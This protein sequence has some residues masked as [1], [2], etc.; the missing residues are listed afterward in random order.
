MDLDQRIDLVMESLMQKYD[1]RV[2]EGGDPYRVLIRTILSQRTR[3]ENTDRASAQLFSQYHTMTE[4][5]GADPARL[6]PLIRPAGFYRVKAQRIV[7]VSKKLLDEFKGQVPDDIK[8][9]LKLPGVG[10]KTANCV[11]V[12]GFQKPAIPVDVHVHRISNRLGLVKTKTPEETEV[13][14]EKIVPKEY[15]IELNDLMVQFGQTICRPQSPRH[16][17]CPLQDICD[18]YQTMKNYDLKDE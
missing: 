10:R 12:Y 7:E 6:E 18:Y 11:L 5:A 15:W 2:F 17:E 1:L 3:D 13:E 14:L 16:E 8:N 9:L 4:I